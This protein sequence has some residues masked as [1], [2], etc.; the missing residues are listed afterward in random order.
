MAGARNLAARN[1]AS[2]ARQVEAFNLLHPAGSRVRA[3]T[4][5]FRDGE[6]K[7]GEIG[8]A[9]AWVLAGH[10]VVVSITGISGCVAISH[11]EACD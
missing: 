6:P 10:T 4:G 2:L 9:G 1:A 8:E 7:V 3:W 11:V 5:H